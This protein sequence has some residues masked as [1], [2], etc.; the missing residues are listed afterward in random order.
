MSG[1][2][3]ACPGGMHAWGG[4]ACPGGIL[5]THAPPPTVNRMTGTCENIA[6]PQTSFAVGK[7]INYYE[8]VFTGGGS[9]G[10][11]YICRRFS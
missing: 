8:W 9:R 1:G 11:A 6:L 3:L 4:H 5:A 2:G 10:A 7:N